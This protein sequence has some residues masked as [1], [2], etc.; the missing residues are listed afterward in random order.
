MCVGR[1]AGYIR[2]LVREVAFIYCPCLGLAWRYLILEI[3]KSPPTAIT[4]P[5]IR[6]ARYQ[7]LLGKVALYA[8]LY[9]DS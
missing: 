4:P 6:V 7:I 9:L 1:I 8:V 5:V 2:S 3:V